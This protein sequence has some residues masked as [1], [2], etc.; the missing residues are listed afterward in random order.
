MPAQTPRLISVLLATYNWPE[1]LQL[2][3]NSLREQTDLDFEIIITDDGSGES[4]RALIEKEQLDFPVP[5]KHLWQEDIGFRKSL[6]LNQGI[7][8]AQG[9]YLVFLDGDC[10]VQNDF[11]AQHRRLAEPHCLV[12]GSRILTS[13]G[14][15][16]E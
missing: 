16:N 4:T 1:A 15:K 13:E 8:A 3:L 12:T 7:A 14:L 2:C 11:I 9:D 6:I 5:I 10:I